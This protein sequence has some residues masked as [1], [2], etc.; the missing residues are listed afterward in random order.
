MRIGRYF[1]VS[2][3]LAF[4]ALFAVVALFSGSL[5]TYAVLTDE[6]LVAELRF[7]QLGPQ[8]FEASLITDA[9]CTLRSFEIYGDQWRLDAQF[10]KWKNWALLLGL[11]AHYRLT[12][13]EGR[14]ASVEEQNTRP[15]LAWALDDEPAFDLVGILS[16][17]SRWNFLVDA[18]YGSST[19]LPID[20]QMLYSVYRTQT[21]L[22]ARS[23]ELPPQRESA[24]ALTVEIRNACGRR[25]GVWERFAVW[26]DHG[27][28]RMLG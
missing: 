10:L 4:V 2:F 3:T 20:T 21:G 7:A 5:Y 11:D 17:T 28:G 24:E 1:K 27:V 6:A 9:G 19:F 23:A 12:R 25:P 13:I 22:I 14:Y 26:L 8:R 16:E 15:N 18:T